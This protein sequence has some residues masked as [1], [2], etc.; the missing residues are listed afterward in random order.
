MALWQDIDGGGSG[1]RGKMLA[2]TICLS[3]NVGSRDELTHLKL[4]VSSS[5]VV[6]LL[7]VEVIVISRIDTTENHL[8]KATQYVI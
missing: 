1:R 6:G 2:Q 7:E 4:L 3:L 5:F 8:I